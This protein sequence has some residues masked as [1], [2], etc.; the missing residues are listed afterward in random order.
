MSILGAMY[1]AV[2]GLGAQS[3]KL[4]VISDNISNSS[5]TGY[6]RSEV[7]FSSLVTQQ[8]SNHSYSSGGVQSDVRRQGDKQGLL[9]STSSTT[10]IPT[11]GAGFLRH[12]NPPH[13][14]TPG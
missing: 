13:P 4:G 5:T 8:I 9:Q 14:H 3:T 12:T 6:K 11:N 2:S 10:H 7:E 1:S